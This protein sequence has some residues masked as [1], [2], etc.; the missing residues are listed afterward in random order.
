MAAPSRRRPLFGGGG[1]GGLYVAGSC[2]NQDESCA[3]WAATGECE[4]AT[5]ECE[6]HAVPLRRLVHTLQAGPYLPRSPHI[7]CIQGRAMSPHVSPY[8]PISPPYL[9]HTLQAGSYLPMSPHVSPY[10]PHIS[11]TH[12][13]QA[14]PD[15][16]SL[17]HLSPTSPPHLP[18]ISPTSP[19]Y[20]PRGRRARRAGRQLL[21]GASAAL[22][23]HGRGGALRG[24]RRRL[25]ARQPVVARRAGVI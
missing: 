19:L 7:S 14:R 13:R 8:L 6:L 9:V 20:L 17:P 22:P 25:P 16:A 1:G 10:L 2:A 21:G 15:S 23:V 3:G 4:A 5:G 11:C 18:H 24:Q 12:C